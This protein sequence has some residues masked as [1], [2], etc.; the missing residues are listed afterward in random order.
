M[1]PLPKFTISELELDR[2]QDYEGQIVLL[3][4][5]DGRMDVVG[6]RINKATKGALARF[7]ASKGF[8]DLEAGKVMTLS[9]PTGLMARAVSLAKIDRNCTQGAARSCGVEIAKA[10][11]SERFVIACSKFKRISDLIEGMAL[12]NYEYLDQK[13]DAAP[14]PFDVEVMGPDALEQ[15]A[16]IET[17]LAVLDGVF[18]TR[19]LTNAPANVLTTSHFAEQ[20]VALSD[21]GLEVEVLEEAELE[22]LG[23][24]TLLC[25]G[26]GSDSPSKVVVMR[27]TGGGEEA[28]FALVG[29]GVVFDT[30]G[31][32]LKPA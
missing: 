25:V 12:R 10:S 3:V 11:V 9:Y 31:I 21:L 17:K 18:F 6:R 14:K 24:R 29:K 27:W 19:D 4:Q 15:Q 7:L 13:S 5:E 16:E 30:G 23:M 22:K 8:E 2:L 26:Q 28:P 1:T 20:L 32:S